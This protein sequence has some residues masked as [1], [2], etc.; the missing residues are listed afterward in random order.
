MS[1]LEDQKKIHIENLGH[2]TF[3]VKKGGLKILT[4]PFLTDSAGGIKRVLPPPV[5]P[6]DIFPDIVLISHAHYDHLDLKTLK[7]LCG[8]FVIVTS[9]NCKKA[10][11]VEKEVIEL[12]NF[13]STV[14]KGVRITKVPAFH[15][16]GRNLLYSDTGVGGFIFEIDG[17]KFYFAGDTAFSCS[18]YGSISEK[19]PDIDFAMLPIGGFMPFPF[20]KFHQTP[21]EAIR[22]FRIL[23]AKYLIPVHFGTWHLVPFYLKKEKA[24]ERLKTYSYICNLQE[25]IRV[26]EPGCSL[27]FDF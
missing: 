2:S 15:N 13:E 9:E 20:R 11:K 4:D 10:V 23:R 22:G 12:R 18:L 17:L 16:K 5:S 1:T 14:I 25:N 6:Q 3:L 27:I 26:I 8:N 7:R 21:E 24:V 19:F